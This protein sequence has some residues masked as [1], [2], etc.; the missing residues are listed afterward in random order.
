VETEGEAM[1]ADAEMLRTGN[2]PVVT[3][4]VTRVVE[5]LSNP[6]N[7]FKGNLVYPKPMKFDT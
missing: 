2:A 3:N 7:V 5:L 4:M 1:K 6:I